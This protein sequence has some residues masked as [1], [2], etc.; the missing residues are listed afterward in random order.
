MVYKIICVQKQSYRV[1]HQERYSENTKQA[2]RRKTKQKRDLN[3][4]ALQHYWNHARTDAPP[5]IHSTPAEHLS[6][7]KHIWG[8]ASVCQKS[9]Q[10]LKL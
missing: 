8:T 2:R 4:A 7:G 5:R 1:I 9:F 3:I 10:R 6:P